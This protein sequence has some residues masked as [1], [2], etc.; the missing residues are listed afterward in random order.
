MAKV[1]PPRTDIADVLAGIRKG[2][3]QRYA[4]ELLAQVCSAVL[5]HKKK[6]TLTL[7]FTV[8]PNPKDDAYAVELDIKINVPTEGYATTYFIDERG[9]LTRDLPEK[10]GMFPHPDEPELP[11]DTPAA[12]VR[13]LPRR[14]TTA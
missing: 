3:A 13:H 7:V 5:L 2:A 1:T 6:G 8:S 10:P 11:T 12:A 14:D 4:S 9:N